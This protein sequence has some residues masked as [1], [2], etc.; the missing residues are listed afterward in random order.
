[1]AVLERV[2]G[3]LEIRIYD[4]NSNIWY[5]LEMDEEIYSLAFEENYDWDSEFLRLTANS[6][7]RLSK[8]GGCDNVDDIF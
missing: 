2:D 5:N 1:M 4:F 3:N 7:E 8:T 6:D